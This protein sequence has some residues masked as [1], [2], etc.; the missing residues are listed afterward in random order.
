MENIPS[1]R[2]RN[3]N[4]L[5]QE[6]SLAS[7]PKAKARDTVCFSAFVLFPFSPYEPLQS[8]CQHSWYVSRSL[9]AACSPGSI[10][11]MPENKWVWLCPASFICFMVKKSKRE[12][13]DTLVDCNYFYLHSESNGNYLYPCICAWAHTH[14]WIL[15][16]LIC[17]PY[18]LA[19]LKTNGGYFNIYEAHLPIY[20]AGCR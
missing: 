15:F 20:L 2:W 7:V 1:I 14:I 16:T 12:V 19:E 3:I 5:N 17:F 11:K 18:P 10:F 8:A 13:F 9:Y 4:T 6:Q